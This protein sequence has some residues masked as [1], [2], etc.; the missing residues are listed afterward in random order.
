MQIVD[1]GPCVKFLGIIVICD[2]PTRCMQLSSHIYILELLG[3]WNLASCH[4]APSP[5][6]PSLPDLSLAPPNS[7]LDISDVDLVLKYQHLVDCLLYLAIATRPDVS[8]YA[9][10]LGQF[11]A[12]PTCAHF[13]LAKHALW[14]LAG[15]NLALC[16]GTP[17]SCI[18][19]SLS[20]YMQNVGCSDADWASNATNRKSIS[21]YSF[22]FQGSLVSWSA[23]KQKSITLSSTEAEYYVVAHTFKEGL[24]LRTF[25]GL[26]RLPVPHPFSYS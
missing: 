7:L 1:L 6:P 24:W 9:M 10:W 14:Y 4:V 19:S 26:L 5:F 22:Y 18:P 17:P 3:E 15:C 16:L 21:C 2:H 13:L 23:V 11:N 20:G 12:V 25:L 8:Y